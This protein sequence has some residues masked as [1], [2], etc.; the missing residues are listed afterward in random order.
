MSEDSYREAHGPA[1]VTQAQDGD[2]DQIIQAELDRL[3]IN[4]LVEVGTDHHSDRD[5]NLLS[6]IHENLDEY[7]WQQEGDQLDK[8]DDDSGSEDSNDSYHSDGEDE[9]EDYEDIVI[10]TIS[11]YNFQLGP[12]TQ[13]SPPRLSPSYS[14]TPQRADYRSVPSRPLPPLPT[15]K[16]ANPNVPKPGPAK[17][18]QRSGP[19]E[20]LEE[21]KQCHYLPEMAMKQLCEMVKECLMEGKPNFLFL[22]YTYLL[23]LI[24]RIKYS[25]RANS[26]HNLRRYTWSIL[27]YT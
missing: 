25:A 5:T 2:V 11:L 19:D 9:D 22:M 21:A 16:M 18:S 17:L 14:V 7:E 6:P 13:Q 10:P 15:K 4:R 26:S 24:S 3:P 20:W 12:A 23:T 27:R 8:E 1:Q